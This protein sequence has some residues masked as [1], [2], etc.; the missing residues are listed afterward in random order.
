MLRRI[1]AAACLLSLLLSSRLGGADTSSTGVWVASPREAARLAR[2]E[3]SLPGLEAAG[4][5]R[6]D[7][8]AWLALY[9]APGL[10][11]AVFDDFKL[12]WAKGYGLKAAGEAGRVTL[13][14]LFQAG[15]ISKPVAAIAALQQVER[16]TL[17]LDTDINATLRSWKVPDNDFTRT[18]KVTL[19]RLLSHRA[20]LTVHGFPGYAVTAPVPTIVQVLDGAKPANTPP[21]RVDLAPGSRFRYSGGGTTVVQLALQDL[22]GR[23]FPAIMEDAV[24]RPLGLRHSTYEN[25]LPAA[26]AARA[27]TGHQAS[28]RQVDGRWHIYPEM[29][30]AGLWTTPSD[31]AAI[32]IDVARARRGDTGRLLKPATA[33]EM[34]TPASRD[35]PGDD[36]PG[37]GFFVDRTGRTDR[38]G[39]NG[40]DEG[41]QAVLVAYAATG[42]GA[43]VM[44]NSD[45]G[46]AAA[47]PLLDAI[48]REYGWPRHEPWQPGVGVLLTAAR[49]RGG[50][51]AIVA[52]YRQLRRA[53]PASA[54]S[55]G[56]LNGIG[57][58]LLRSGDTDGA[59]RI[60][61]LNVEFYP[62]Y[63]D[64]YD[65]LAE[66]YMVAGRHALAVEHYRKSLALDPKNT[67]A[68]QMLEK[69]GAAPAAK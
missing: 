19:R 15:S 27:A 24:I 52:E 8:A 34:L 5:P 61:A 14:T 1:A 32:A 23:P 63:G 41:F 44:V 18:E 21:V 9:D 46:N 48:A 55:P 36:T 31:L 53:R 12:V 58:R 50:V 65:S 66:G 38:F 60:F 68:V 40:A 37:L 26:R 59:I 51:D 25:P 4:Q 28:G 20:G 17:Q 47:G 13:E 42:R 56:H 35:E 57:Y 69:L 39:H 29:A 64:A 43:A 30:A 3:A 67:N 49:K 7:V 62:Q 33:A 54:F 22:L 45:N 10:S 16:G 11:V 2:V 6:M